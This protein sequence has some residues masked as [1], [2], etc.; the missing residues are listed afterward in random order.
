M[1]PRTTFE[2]RVT[3]NNFF[4]P[5]RYTSAS[6][7]VKSRSI[8]LASITSLTNFRPLPRFS[9]ARPDKNSVRHFNRLHMC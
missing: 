4:A 6:P 9:G 2:P 7:L 1:Q 3:R 5:L 8:G